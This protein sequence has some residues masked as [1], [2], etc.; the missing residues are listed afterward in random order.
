LVQLDALSGTVLARV[1]PLPNP[2]GVATTSAGRVIVAHVYAE[3]MAFTPM[4]GEGGG[5]A[6]NES[7]LKLRNA[8]PA[9]FVVEAYDDIDLD[10]AIRPSRALSVVR[11]PADGDAYVVHVLTM[12]GVVN[13][14]TEV[15]VTEEKTTHSGGGYGGTPSSTTTVTT[16]Q[17]QLPD[18]PRPI[19]VSVTRIADTG[20][21]PSVSQSAHAF[22]VINS[23][24]G[25]ILSTVVDQP[26]DINHHPTK[27]LLF[28]TGYGSDN[29][30]VLNSRNDDPMRFPLAVIE[31]GHAPKAV[32]FSADGSRAYVLNEHAYTVSVINI[33]E[34]LGGQVVGDRIAPVHRP[35]ALQ[36]E[37]TFGKDPL[38]QKIRNGRRVFTFAQ[39]WRL[40]QRGRFACAT[41]HLEGTEDKMTWVLPDGPRQTPAL[42]HRLAGTAPFNWRGT[43]GALH[44]N[45]SRT[46]H[47]MGGQG[48][49]CYQLDD[50]EE[51]LLHGMP[52]P[53]ENPHVSPGGEL[54]EAQ[55]RG[56]GIFFDAE[57][58]CADCH[59]GVASNDGRLHDVGTTS[60]ERELRCAAGGDCEAPVVIN[61]PSLKGLY[62][63]APYLHDGSAATLHDVIEQTLDTMGRTSHL[64]DGQKA[65]LV[66][67]L[68][69][70]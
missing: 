43:E 45:M 39:N 57:V 28:V 8:N 30:L 25:Y 59:G 65:D 62:Y 5:F 51:F 4:A 61:T 40:S 38:S 66:A 13:P 42:T 50:L 37:T 49:N 26:S 3:A 24:E 29:V 58:G 52:A 33:D 44:D 60:H 6:K 68:L 9:A 1:D 41:C 11:D 17:V 27:S 15:E 22:P 67:Y 7:L 36:P 56:A 54:N 10:E 34:V 47:R 69:T 20:S 70:L 35:R 63:T 23:S 16:K 2:R 32:T 18:L 53:P 12:P 19:E 31:V 46:I 14:A 64:T 21:G 48:L 55:K